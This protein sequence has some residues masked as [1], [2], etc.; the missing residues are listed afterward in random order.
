ML[1]VISWIC[2][3]LVVGLIARLLVPGRQAMGMLATIMLG[4]VGS[5]IGGAISW[6]IRGGQPDMYQPSGW[7]MSIIGAIICVV[8][9]TRMQRTA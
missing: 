5:L 7:I 3:G 9:A 1:A 2:F 4:V 8:V 6:L